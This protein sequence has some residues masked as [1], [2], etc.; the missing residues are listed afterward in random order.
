MQL[1]RWT[2]GVLA[3]GALTLHQLAKVVLQE[4]IETFFGLCGGQFG[5]DWQVVALKRIV[6]RYEFFIF[7]G[8]TRIATFLAHLS[9]ACFA[10]KL[11]FFLL[12]GVNL[13]A[14][15]QFFAEFNQRSVMVWFHCFR[16]FLGFDIFC[17]EQWDFCIIGA[18][19]WTLFEIKS[20][21]CYRNAWRRRN[22]PN[23]FSHS[24]PQLDAQGTVRR[25][26]NPLNH[27]ALFT[28]V[29]FKGYRAV[30]QT[31]VSVR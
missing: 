23:N 13:R 19:L 17:E 29:D 22:M 4:L 28:S 25:D 18:I 16:L 2:S 14:Q 31:Y 24:P 30:L 27:L 8:F 11:L 1:A 12:G 15:H 9:I 20:C 26:F 7:L 10:Q 3:I 21:N 5:L 6:A